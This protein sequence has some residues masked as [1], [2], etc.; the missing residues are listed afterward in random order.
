MP[1]SGPLGAGALDFWMLGGERH[2]GHPQPEGC[3]PRGKQHGIGGEVYSPMTPP[4]GACPVSQQPLPR[5]AGTGCA[6]EL[7]PRLV[8][9][10]PGPKASV[11]GHGAK[12]SQQRLAFLDIVSDQLFAHRSFVLS[13]LF[14]K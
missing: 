2:A 6:G 8:E 13:F 4:P 5:R 11:T 10:T 7:G 14:Y 9:G 12:Q 3:G 1:S